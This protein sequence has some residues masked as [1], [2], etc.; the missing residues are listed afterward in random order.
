MSQHYS[1]R[2]VLSSIAGVAGTVGVAGV[3]SAG[4]PA[5]TARFGAFN[6]F[7]FDT[8]QVQQRGDDQAAAA[9]RIIQETRPDVLVVNELT[10]N[11]QQGKATG[12]TNAQAFLENYLSVSQGKRL[13]PID[14]EYTYQ[15][16]V[17]TGV[18]SG[19]DLNNDGEVDTS[20]GDFEYANDAFGFGLFP[21]QYG[22]SV[23]SQYPIQESG[24]RT[25]R[26]FLWQDMPD[27]HIATD[28]DTDLYLTQDETE[29]FRLSSKTHAAVPID[30][31]GRTIYGLFAHP[32]PPVFDG[33]GNFNGRR[34]YD[35]IRL[36]YD[37]ARGADYPYDDSGHS[38]GLPADASYVLMG[39][40]NAYPGSAESLY[41]AEELLLDG[42]VFSDRRLPTSPGGA[43]EG[44]RYATA[45]FN[46]GA[47]VD[48]VRPSPDL[49]MRDGSVV[50]PSEHANKRGLAED[51]QTAS[52]HRMVWAD[53]DV[54]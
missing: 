38:G 6:V 50:W 36:L 23:Y 14:Y 3:A 28:S 37:V 13:D 20:R 9:A 41:A 12:T 46:D 29:R 54:R 22:F 17:N 2:A 31:E 43:Q 53:L 8:E 40:M 15:P 26:K 18:A 30:V 5:H 19:M 25:F 7:E 10:N 42:E 16:T 21:G 4:Q 49:Q 1:R 39:D 32:T 27:S 35:E 34:N 52:D 51:V 47:K 24:I 33:E 44:S 11:L 45:T 48:Y